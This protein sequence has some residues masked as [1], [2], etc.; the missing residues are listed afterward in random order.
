MKYL[1]LLLFVFISGYA[2]YAQ[3]DTLTPGS[4][5]S[6]QQ[7]CYN[8]YP[9]TLVEL[10]SPAGGTGVFAYQWYS[11]PDGSS[12]SAIAGATAKD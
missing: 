2:G 9:D 1:T 4:I 7:I 6:N 5:G 3:T 8:S 11:S 12:W 10:T